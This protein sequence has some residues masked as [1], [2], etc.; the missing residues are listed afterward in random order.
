MLFGKIYDVLGRKDIFS[1]GLS[2]K[3]NFSE[4]EAMAFTKLNFD[5]N[6]DLKKDAAM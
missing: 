4:L 1:V 6:R 2:P 5:N 3:S